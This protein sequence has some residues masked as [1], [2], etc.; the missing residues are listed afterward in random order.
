MK[1]NIN[2]SYMKRRMDSTYSMQLLIVAI[3]FLI[4]YSITRDLFFR[5]AS[6]LIATI[7]IIFRWRVNKKS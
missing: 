7:W 6:A 5:F 4:L 3:L 1:E 2:Y